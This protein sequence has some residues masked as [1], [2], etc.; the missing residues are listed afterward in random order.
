MERASRQMHIAMTVEC[1]IKILD[2]VKPTRR[3]WLARC[4]AHKDRSPSLSIREGEDGRIVLHDFAGC[5]PAAICA[6]L[7]LSLRDL[8]SNNDLPFSELARTR[9]E[10]EARRAAEENQHRREGFT[11][12]ACREADTFIRSR[13]GLDISAW[14]L[15]RLDEELNALADA[16]YI[17]RC[18][19]LDGQS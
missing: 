14:T 2:G 15:Q 17:L 11:I 12:D 9:R 13:R 7:G 5:E 3:G 10:R 18:E 16:Y 6:A 1:F 19:E 4:P 8:F